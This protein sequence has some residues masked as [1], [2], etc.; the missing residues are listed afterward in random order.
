LD[1]GPSGVVASAFSNLDRTTC[2]D[3]QPTT[4]SSTIELLEALMLHDRRRI[5]LP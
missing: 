2:N 1:G 5:F 4:T 3:L